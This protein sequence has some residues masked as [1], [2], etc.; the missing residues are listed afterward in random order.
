MRQPGDWVLVSPMDIQT[1][2]LLTRRGL[3]R[4]APLALPFAGSAHAAET[5]T[6][7]FPSHTPEVVREMVT[8]AHGNV[9]RVKELVDARPSLAKAAVDWGFGDWEDALGAA[10]HVGN[11]EIA[12]Y[13]IG[14]GAR[15]TLFSA[16]MLGQ[17][18]T[19]KAFLAAQPGAQ[20]IAGPHSISLLAHAK[21]GGKQ[22]EAVY[23]YLDSLGD[24]GAAKAAPLA[25]S[26]IAALT[27]TYVFGSGATERIEIT[28][29]NGQL[30][31]TRTGKTPRNLVHLGDHTFH[32]AGAAAVRIHFS[33]SG[34]SAALTVE[35]PD[36]ILTARR[37]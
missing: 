28:E 30:I 12:E 22:A 6:D 5:V 29:K 1:G 35:D 34:E 4:F 20:R 3:W 32:P 26:E 17:L 36:L 16:T 24:A 27:G 23:Q 10:S 15:P 7:A 9:K 18:D 37:T 2:F 8:V 13:L 11:R 14:K 21:A 19:V 33:G 25:A 31:F